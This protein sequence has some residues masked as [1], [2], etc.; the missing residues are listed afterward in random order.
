MSAPISSS[1]GPHSTFF[2]RMRS[3]SGDMV[4]LAVP[5]IITLVI[6]TLI[7]FVDTLMISPLGTLPLA[8]MAIV[9]SVM[10][11]P[12]S[13][14]YGMSSIIGVRFAQTIGGGNTE[15]IAVDFWNG[16][17]L[18]AL[19]GGLSALLMIAAF[20]VLEIIGQPA[21]VLEV[22]WP[23]WVSMSILLIPFT[24]L[25]VA[26]SLFEAMGRPWIATAFIFAAVIVNVP[27][28]YMLIFGL[29]NWDGLGLLG[30][31]IASLI[32][33]I[34]GLIL[35]LA[36]CRMEPRLKYLTRFSPICL[37]TLLGQFKEGLPITLTYT[38]EGGAYALAGLMLGWF[39]AAALAANQIVAS[40]SV[41]LYM[42]PLGVSAAL[43][44]RVGLA[45]GAQERI[46]LRP[47]GAVG[48]SFACSWMVLAAILV[49]LLAE[50]ISEALGRD[51]EV[52]AITSA[53]FVVVAAL[54]ILD[55]LQSTALGA[56]RG[57]KDNIWPTMVSLVAYWIIALPAAYLIGVVAQLGPVGIWIGYGVGLLVPAVLLPLRYFRK[58]AS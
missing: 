23:Y 57:L 22:L 7:V 4:R 37:K 53:L 24:M 25:H 14:L 55:S 36:F 39:G 58:A 40:I 35:A 32:S 20:P 33:E 47:I 9:T 6:S 42:I 21:E 10:V 30:A 17:V 27:A 5:M 1:T 41:T 18:T 16:L 54:Q 48:L 19:S 31:G 34:T 51:P 26:R 50:P 2:D 49:L 43:S 56:L 8:A 52:I 12:Y 13:A 44:I 45:I 11:I 29:G 28:N 46:R 3:E 38:G 15:Q